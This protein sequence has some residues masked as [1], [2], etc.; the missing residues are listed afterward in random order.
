MYHETIGHGA[1]TY[2]IEVHRSGVA[3]VTHES[4]DGPIA[5]GVPANTMFARNDVPNELCARIN[6]RIA[7]GR[8][9]LGRTPIA[10]E[11]TAT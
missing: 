7:N 9:V 8:E 10:D 2:R 4:K 6:T 3:T 1:T 11:E 5:W